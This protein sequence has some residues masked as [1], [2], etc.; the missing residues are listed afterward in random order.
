MSKVAGL[1]NESL[2]AA[3]KMKRLLFLVAGIYVVSFLAGY[4]MVHFQVPF[5][6]ELSKT[7]IESVSAN[8]VFTPIIGSLMSGNLALAIAFTFLLNLSIGAFVYTTL[9]GVIPILGGVGSVAV[10]GLRGFVIGLTY[11]YAFRVSIG[12]TVVALGTLILELGAYVFS[13]A[14][15]INISL[16]AIF[17]RRYGVESRWTAFKKAWKDASRIYVIVVILLVLGAVWE[18]AGIYISMH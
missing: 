10:T 11:Y 18:M 8:P 1:L 5:A 12:Y 2:F 6:M 3:R 13:A 4:L 7:L 9:I 14:A 17:P 16:S 15:G